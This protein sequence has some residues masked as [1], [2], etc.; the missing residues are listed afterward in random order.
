M[1]LI[2]HNEDSNKKN[3]KYEIEKSLDEG[4]KLTKHISDFQ[5]FIKTVDEFQDLETA[6]K[7]ILND[8][9]RLSGGNKIISESLLKELKNDFKK[10]LEISDKAFIELEY[11]KLSAKKEFDKKYCKS[12]K[13]SF[14]VH[15]SIL[16]LLNKYNF[17]EKIISYLER[18]LFNNEQETPERNLTKIDKKFIE[19]KRLN[20]YSITTV[21][22][23]NEDKNIQI[24]PEGFTHEY[25]KRN[26][27]I[28][29]NILKYY[30]S[31]CVDLISDEEY[32]KEVDRGYFG[33]KETMLI[34][35]SYIYYGA[36]FNRKSLYVKL[37]SLKEDYVLNGKQIKYYQDLIP[38]FKEY[39][40][41]FEKGYNEFE[42]ECI[43]KYLNEY[44]DKT[45]YTNRIFEFVTKKVLFGYSEWFNNGNSSF[46]IKE[47]TK[48]GIKTIT[49][50]F[51]HGEKQ[52]YFYKAWSIILSNNDL[53]KPYFDKL[54]ASSNKQPQ[55]EHNEIKFSD[56]FDLNK[57]ELLKIKE[58]HN[59]F[60]NDRGKNIAALIHLLKSVHEL[61]EIIPSSK[62]KSLK[63]FY[64]LLTGESKKYEAVRKCFDERNNW[65]YTNNDE[66]LQSI[67]KRLNKIIQK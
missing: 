15:K 4:K 38:Y 54:Q 59:S 3:F 25:L 8:V 29:N 36:Y 13:I 2:I 62:T 9:K 12:L 14:I 49:G 18:K 65:N 24:V 21:I 48:T 16:E 10:Q 20:F 45:D 47:D 52:G 63:R 17:K 6:K 58:I 31:P 37:L 64:E 26:F 67:K 66:V 42:N 1:A 51:E 53:Y 55:T 30:Y 44:S 33:N 41:G 43:K 39:A 46:T 7:G 56:F 28:D 61:I 23:G 32:N 40:Q 11:N 35:Y 34:P 5:K 22:F 27:K 19:E 57:V 50:A 60:I